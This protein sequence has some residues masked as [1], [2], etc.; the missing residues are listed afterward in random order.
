MANLFV[1]ITSLVFFFIT[2]I[3]G[4]GVE[5]GHELAGTIAI[6]A[7]PVLFVH[8]LFR[9]KELLFPRRLSILFVLFLL[10]Q[11]VSTFLSVNINQSIL[12]LFY[13]ISIFL[14]S[15][16]AYNYRKQ[17]EKAI[18]VLI[19]S[20]S[21]LFTAYS[22][23]LHSNVFNLFIPQTGFQFVYSRFATHN[24]LG[25]FLALPIIICIYHLYQN[26]K[27]KKLYL[28]LISLI[29]FVFFSYSRSSYL[30]IAI[31]IFALYISHLR[32]FKS[33]PNNIFSRLFVLIVFLLTAFLAIG[34]TTLSQKQVIFSSFNNFLTHN[35]GLQTKY[36]I[37][38][39]LEYYKAAFLSIE[40]SPLFGIGPNN[41]LIASKKYAY[42]STQG[43][44][45]STHNIFTEVAVGQGLLGVLLF[46]SIIAFIFMNSRRTALFFVLLAMLVNFQTDYTYQM[47]SFL[48]LF[49]AVAFILS[50]EKQ[51][52]LSQIMT[53]KVTFISKRSQ[54]PNSKSKRVLFISFFLI[55]GIL[56]CLFLLKIGHFTEKNLSR[57]QLLRQY[58]QK[59]LSECGRVANHLSCYDQEIP[60]LMDKISMSEAFR[61][62]SILS[63]TDK[64]YT[65]CHSLGHAISEKAVDKDPSKWKDVLRACPPVC[66]GGC[67]HGAIVTKFKS[68]R[69]TDKEVEKFKPELKTICVPDNVWNPSPNEIGLCNHG[70]GH[71]HMYITNGDVQKSLALCLYEANNKSESSEY[72]SCSAGTFMQI[73]QAIEHE[74]ID[75][76][77]KI[78]QTKETVANFCQQFNGV[79]F[80]NCHLESF[81]LFKEEVQTS[82]GLDRF[83][84]YL[85]TEKEKLI[86]YHKMFSEVSIWTVLYGNNVPKLISYCNSIKNSMT[87]T[88]M[89]DASIVLVKVDRKNLNKSVDICKKAQNKGDLCFGNLVYYVAKNFDR[90][91]KEFVSFC[92]ELPQNFSQKCGK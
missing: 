53:S 21:Y 43:T 40:K 16:I 26:R 63:E 31:A 27:M 13:S 76:V 29:P 59:I 57:E 24:H 12:Y 11:C 91:S 30:S 23:A 38:N 48:L 87:E 69:L 65:H 32:K 80:T 39:R 33:F 56:G 73:Y 52:H 17:F 14:F 37:G 61:V 36:F 22:L 15:L 4:F 58:A 86:C 60:K 45:Q 89:R 85:K 92:S 34:T 67:L 81:P 84:S 35:E 79:A 10:S 72:W 83:C 75:L 1:I 68:V 82:E 44:T 47:Y 74:D 51:S 9:K 55:A 49:F 71:L 62:G 70:L 3:E 88:C 41:F 5:N 6:F 50:D 66:N 46:V 90:K 64:N 42:N 2:V 28:C 20:L 19:F 54:K 18:V 25:D 8:M 7:V 78:K 77:E